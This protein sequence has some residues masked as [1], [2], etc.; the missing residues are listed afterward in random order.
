MKT[1]NL[2]TRLSQTLVPVSPISF[3]QTAVMIFLAGFT[4]IMTALLIGGMRPDGL[5][6]LIQLDVLSA[7]IIAIFAP[8]AALFSG[9][10]GREKVGL[11][12]LILS[13]ILFTL[14]VIPHIIQP[15][16]GQ[17]VTL[18]CAIEILILMPLPLI[19]IFRGLKRTA[20]TS[21]F[22]TAFLG[23]FSAASFGYIA[24]RLV[25][26]IDDPMHHI[27]SHLLPIIFYSIAGGMLGSRYL[28]W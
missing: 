22:T 12:G 15:N 28:K 17:I 3:Y 21:L 6:M 20:P 25:C 26:P 2:I 13:A 14:M 27:V 24:I 11:Y 18:S 4:T 5:S 19:V 16:L 7:F 23:T 9:L 1:D 8:F 10:P